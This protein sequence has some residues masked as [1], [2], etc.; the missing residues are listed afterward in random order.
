MLADESEIRSKRTTN[1]LRHDTK[2][3]GD[4]AAA[5]VASCLET[6]RDVTTCRP[7]AV[8]GHAAVV[9]DGVMLVFFGYSAKFGTL[10]IVQE[11]NFSK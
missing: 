3:T 11:Y 4:A 8:V 1:H 10:N 6:R 7:V 2:P 5:Q 9:V